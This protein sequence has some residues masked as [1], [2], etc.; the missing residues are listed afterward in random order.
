[1]TKRLLPS[2]FNVHNFRPILRRYMK[3]NE[4]KLKTFLNI[5]GWVNTSPI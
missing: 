1:M 3:I 4:I 2:Q 5:S